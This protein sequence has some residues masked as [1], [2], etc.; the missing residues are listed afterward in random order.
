[1]G[2][3]EHD[4]EPSGTIKGTKFIGQLDDYQLLNQASSPRFDSTK[5]GELFFVGYLY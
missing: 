3:S 4:N 5:S 2:S 1:V